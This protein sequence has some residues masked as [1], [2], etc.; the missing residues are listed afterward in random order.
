MS[1][2]KPNRIRFSL[3]VFAFVYPLVTLL[4][5]GLGPLT[6]DWPGWQRTLVMV[7]VI[8][9]SMVFVIIPSIY[10]YFGRWL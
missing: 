3:L 10:K 5:Y 7:P 1:A 2:P 9:L 4:F 8:V 6:E